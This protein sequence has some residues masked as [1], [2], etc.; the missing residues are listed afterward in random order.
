MLAAR[1]NVYSVDVLLFGCFHYYDSLTYRMTIKAPILRFSYLMWNE[2]TQAYTHTHHPASS[3]L[4]YGNG[5]DPTHCAVLRPTCDQSLNSFNSF[6]HTTKTTINDG[7]SRV[8]VYQ[9]ICLLPYHAGLYYLP[10][11]SS[12]PTTVHSPYNTS[13]L[14]YVVSLK[15]KSWLISSLLTPA[16]WTTWLRSSG[17]RYYLNM[18]TAWTSFR[19]RNARHLPK[20]YCKCMKCRKILS[21]PCEM[22]LIYPTDCYG[23]W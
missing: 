9:P 14:W 19:S 7:C 17:I 13:K 4:P 20:F 6:F 8:T 2:Q 21:G 23:H 22:Q 10:R 5:L 3:N 15:L 16:H 11:S 18:W 1:T 12:I